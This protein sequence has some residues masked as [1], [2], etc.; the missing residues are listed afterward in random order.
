[1]PP[2]PIERPDFGTS[3]GEP[4]SGGDFVIVAKSAAKAGLENAITANAVAER[5]DFFTD[6]PNSNLIP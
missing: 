1:L 4:A 2:R 3:E 6:A 5:R